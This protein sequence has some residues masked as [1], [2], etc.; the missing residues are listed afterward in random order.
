MEKIKA[1]HSQEMAAK[2]NNTM[3]HKVIIKEDDNIFATLACKS[4]MDGIASFLSDDWSANMAR[5]IGWSDFA[6]WIDNKEAQENPENAKK[7]S[8]I[9]KGLRAMVKHPLLTIASIATVAFCGVKLYN[10]I[11]KTQ[12]TTTAVSSVVEDT[13]KVVQAPTKPIVKPPKE[14]EYTAE[15]LKIVN[16]RINAGLAYEKEIGY[17]NLEILKDLSTEDKKRIKSYLDIEFDRRRSFIGFAAGERS[18]T[19]ECVDSS[20][21]DL[22]DCLRS[23]KIAVAEFFWDKGGDLLINKESARKI[24]TENLELF[25][26]R[27]N[28]PSTSTVKDVEN[29]VFSSSFSPLKTKGKFDD[30]IQLIMGNDIDDACHAQIVKDIKKCFD[31]Y[32]YPGK[33]T[34]L[35]E[36]KAIL[37]KSVMDSKSSYS[38]M[39]QGFR[40]ELIKKIDAFPQESFGKIIKEPIEVF[41]N[42]KSELLEFKRLVRLAEKLEKAQ[43]QGSMISFN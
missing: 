26:K 33:A 21:F 9:S 16:D 12:Q 39:S 18:A 41:Q 30:L 8:F 29:L 28:L 3:P 27:L 34:N 10:H 40:D 36:Y 5:K 42:P 25:Q 2:L 17:S 32:F 20:R 31:R 37:K 24:I 43:K 4:G 35:E 23:D 22:F 14:L 19:L 1:I 7:E 38:T 13:A 15:N 6:D 11:N